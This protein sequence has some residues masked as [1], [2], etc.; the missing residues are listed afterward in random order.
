MSGI[1]DWILEIGAGCVTE[2]DVANQSASIAGESFG[3]SDAPGG[4]GD[5]GTEAGKA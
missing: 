3:G 4:G 2:W 1:W 5:V